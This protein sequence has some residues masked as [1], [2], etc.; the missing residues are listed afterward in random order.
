MNRCF[1]LAMSLICFT[2]VSHVAEAQT[3]QVLQLLGRHT[4]RPATFDKGS[5]EVVTYDPASKTAIISDA[6]GNKISFINV[7]NPANPVLIRDVLLTA[8]SGIVNGVAVKNGLVAVALEDATRKSNPGKV[9]FFDMAGV[10]R[11]SIAVGALPDMIA[12]TPNGQRLIVCN[13]AEPE[14]NYT[15]DAEGTVSIINV[16]NP[17][18]PTVQTVDFRLLNG[19]QDSLRALGIRIYGPNATVAQDFEPEYAAI[20]ADGATAYITLQENNAIA[21]IDINNAALLRVTALGFKDYSKGLARSTNYPWTVRPSIGTTPAG[22]NISLGG[23]SGLWFTGYG[24]DTTKLRFLTHP[25]RG[26]NGEPV[27][28]RG[29]L[30]R[31]FALPNL[32]AEVIAI[33]LDRTTGAYT[34]LSRTSLFRTDGITPISGRPN[35]QAAGQGVAYTDEL[36]V[37]HLVMIFLTIRSVET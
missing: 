13:E 32:Q 30:R 4:Q 34:I 14:V 16:T 7:T 28:L 33:E 12:F 35:L 26:P 20:S 21:V 36:P 11:S 15:F 23:L 18:V 22:Q 24:A 19:K 5:A 27:T 17:A 9:L 37:D 25:D 3:A 31:P 2:L 29:Q 6:N 8:Y 1:F 10:F